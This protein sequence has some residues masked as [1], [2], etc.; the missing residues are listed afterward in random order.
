M[1]IRGMDYVQFH[2][3]GDTVIGKTLEDLLSMT[4]NNTAG[5]DF[6]TYELKT[7]RKVSASMLMLFTKALFPPNANKKSLEVFGFA[8]RKT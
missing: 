8:P 3:K 1:E 2:R 7:G 4:K 6:A 5:P